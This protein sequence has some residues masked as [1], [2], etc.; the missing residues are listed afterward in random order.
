[1]RKD[2]HHEYI[3][4]KKYKRTSQ[5]LAKHKYQHM[6]CSDNNRYYYI[7]IILSLAEERRNTEYKDNL[8]KLRRPYGNTK[9]GKRKLT[10]VCGHT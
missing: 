3:R 2:K 8:Y 5:I 4:Y 6:N 7:N 10:S 1:M 9:N